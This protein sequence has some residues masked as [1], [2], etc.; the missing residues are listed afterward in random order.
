M[1]N[2]DVEPV[3]PV[4]VADQNHVQNIQI[5]TPKLQKFKFIYKTSKYFRTAE[6]TTFKS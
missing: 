4:S 2:K 5:G 3:K 1:V 6:E